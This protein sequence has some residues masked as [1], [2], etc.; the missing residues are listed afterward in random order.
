MQLCPRTK[1]GRE[2]MNEKE[3]INLLNCPYSERTNRWLSLFNQHIITALEFNRFCHHMLNPERNIEGLNARQ[4]AISG[5]AEIRRIIWWREKKD[6][7]KN[8]KTNTYRRNNRK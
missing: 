4:L 2:K 6:E 1:K 8:N 3:R 7:G 5:K